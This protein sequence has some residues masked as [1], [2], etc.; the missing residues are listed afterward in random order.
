M[1]LRTVLLRR[2]PES[3]S[4]FAHLGAVASVFDSWSL[5]LGCLWN[6]RGDIDVEVSKS[7]SNHSHI[8]CNLGL[9][10]HVPYIICTIFTVWLYV[11]I[12]WCCVYVYVYIYILYIYRKVDLLV[13]H[14][15]AT[16]FPCSLLMRSCLVGCSHF[17]GMFISKLFWSNIVEM[18]C[19]S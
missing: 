14:V 4:G 3:D 5:V 11:Y 2:Q 16:C 13:G 15:V 8:M 18:E 7:V 17:L 10:K 9:A 6:L 1:L 19:I 12:V